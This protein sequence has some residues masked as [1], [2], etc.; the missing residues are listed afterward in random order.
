MAP[1]R[2]GFERATIRRVAA[3]A[4]VSPST[5]SRTFSHPHL[6]RPST[7]ERVSS[8]AA[9]LGY[10]PDGSAQALTTGRRGVIGLVVPDIANA[11]FPP[12]IRAAQ[13][14]AERA[15]LSTIIGDGNEDGTK[16]AAMVSRLR[17]QTDGVIL[18]SS[19]A[20]E[21]VLRS[22]HEVTRLV[23]VNRDL[24]GVPRVLIDSAPGMRAC[25]GLLAGL[26]H[27]RI[28][29]VNGPATSWSNGERLAAIED[30]CR[31]HDIVL[32]TLQARLPDHRGGR[33][34]A[35]EVLELGVTAAIAFDDVLGQGLLAGLAE[36]GVRVPEQFSLTACD[37]TVSA[38]T[39]PPMTTVGCPVREAGEAAVELLVEALGGVD[40]ERV[41]RLP[42][43]MV[44]RGTTGP[45]PA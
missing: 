20:P 29:Y 32:T 26:G 41:R 38:T 42:A 36:R 22:L 21:A 39:Y 12:L 18:A 13:T 27:T 45:V 31:E 25:V 6:L 30:A 2:G 4:G 10:V 34:A 1:S 24:A 9:E 44:V 8:V 23:L 15:G 28:A 43:D 7:V 40:E 3:V 35:A 33:A 5:V 14:A 19:R 17:G 37:D 11:F 16:E